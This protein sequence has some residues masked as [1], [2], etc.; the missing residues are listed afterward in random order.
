MRGHRLTRI[1]F[2]LAE[3]EGRDKGGNARVDVDDRAAS[4]IECAHFKQQTAA[5]PHHVRDR[6]VDDRQPDSDE[7]HYSGKLHA[8]NRSAQNQRCSDGRKGHLKADKDIFADD[9]IRECGCRAVRRG[10]RQEQVAPA[11]ECVAFRSK[12]SAVAP[13]YP[14]KH[15]QRRCG[16]DLCH[17]G[18]HILGPCQAAIK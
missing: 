2:A 1:A 18:E 17:R 14:D 8:F 3:N 13:H 9:L 11:E 16:A 7:D 12:G 5:G 6:E 10:G 15:G 4:E